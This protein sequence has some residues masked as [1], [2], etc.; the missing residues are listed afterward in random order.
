MP[1]NLITILK[2]QHNILRKEM[3]EIKVK[4]E[5]E[6]PD[7]IL[8]AGDL[9]N[10]KKSL[11]DH[12]ALEDNIF[13]PQLIDKFKKQN[14]NIDNIIRFID[15]MKII[16]KKTMFFLAKYEKAENI[17]SDFPNFKSSL[18]EII[19]TLLIR[20]ES[21]EDGVYLYWQ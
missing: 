3:K 15:E 1:E 9:V 11:L 5:S 7:S 18:Y 4:T 20:I 21:E 10:F 16:G 13:Y 19:S 14:L 17:Q 8:I 12:L 2:G 6:T